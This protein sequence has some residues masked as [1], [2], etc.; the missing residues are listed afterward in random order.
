[1]FFRQFT[2]REK[3]I[4]GGMV[5][6]LLAVMYV[7]LVHHPI[8]ERYLELEASRA[9]AELALANTQA[10]AYRYN[11]MQA[12]L[13]EI[14]SM[15]EDEITVMPPYDNLN[16]LLTLF[17]GI[18]IGS[19]PQFSYAPPEIHGNVAVRTIRISYTASSYEQARSILEQLAAGEIPMKRELVEYRMPDGST[20]LRELPVPDWIA[21]EAA[22]QTPMYQALDHAY[23]I[24]EAWCRNPA[25]AESFPP[26]VF[27]ITDGEATDCDEEELRT[28]CER[29]RSLRTCDGH[30]L[31]I[32]IHIAPDE[33]QHAVFFPTE[34]EAAYSNRYAG[35]LYDCSSPMPEV[36]NEAIREAKGPGALPPFRGMSYN[37]SAEQLIAMLNIGSISV[38]TE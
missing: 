8:E 15:D 3:L 30:V 13:E 23:E 26:T 28:I 22:G 36:F 37:T 9:D 18:F 29:I 27:N 35:V 7:L 32:N 20:S 11:S 17:N 12:E 38:K 34:E 2:H 4:L 24:A 10:K 1:M 6:V 5:A 31:L 19:Q 21:A 33:S 16:T 25:H 14:F